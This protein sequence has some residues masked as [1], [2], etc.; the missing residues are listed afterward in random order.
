MSNGTTSV[1]CYVV[2]CGAHLPR[3]ATV[4]ILYDGERR[5]D[6]SLSS[7]RFVEDL[8]NGVSSMHGDYG[9]GCVLRSMHG[10]LLFFFLR[11]TPMERGGGGGDYMY[12]VRNNY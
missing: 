11:V 12:L 6:E 2:L 8:R 5:C 10:K 9:L 4:E 3:Y 7:K 1:L